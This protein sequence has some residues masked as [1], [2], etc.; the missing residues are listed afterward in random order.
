MSLIALPCLSSPCKNGGT[1]TNIGTTDYQCDCPDDYNDGEDCNECELIF[2][3]VAWFLFE[4]LN[5]KNYFYF[6]I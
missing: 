3:V 1:C 6:L 4:L 2:P 5:I